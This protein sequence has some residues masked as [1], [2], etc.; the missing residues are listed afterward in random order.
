MDQIHLMCYDY[1][2]AWE[3]TTGHNSPL[4]A[5]PAYDK[6]DNIYLNAVQ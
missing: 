2:G 1:H 6:G 5:N 4:Y 3:T